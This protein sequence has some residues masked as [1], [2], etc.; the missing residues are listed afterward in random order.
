MSGVVVDTSVWID[1]FAGRPV[2]SLEDALSQGAVVLSPIVV[3]ELVSGARKPKERAAIE[4]LLDELPLHP[5]PL[6]H[7]VHVGELRR[8][9]AT[10]G[11]AISTSDAHVA[12]CALDRHAVLLARDDVFRRI[13][14][15]TDLRVRTE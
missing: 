1:F 10:A 13:A 12:Q 5:T 4:D 2:P 15:L 3:A 8:K 6:D 14:P 11:L 7:W 9:L